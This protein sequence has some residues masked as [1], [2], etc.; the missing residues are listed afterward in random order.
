VHA[1]L[2]AHSSFADSENLS[3]HSGLPRIA[4]V[5][6][7]GTGKSAFAVRVAQTLRT[8]TGICAEIVSAD[9]MQLYRG[10]DIGTAKIPVAE[11]R[12]IAHHMLDVLEP[13]Q[14]AAVAAYQRD[15]HRAF[16]AIESRGNVPILV[17]GSGLYVNAALYTFHFPGSDPKV[18]SDLNARFERDGLAP[19]AEELVARD[20]NAHTTVDLKNPRR[21]IRALEVLKIT[22]EP[23]AAQLPAKPEPVRPVLTFGLHEERETLV[24]RLDERVTQMWRLGLVEEVRRLIPRGLQNGPTASRAIG[25]A[26]ALAYVHGQLSETEAIEQTQKLTRRY[27]RRQVSWFKRLPDV[28][29]LTSAE[30]TTDEA[31]EQV[32]RQWQQH[33]Q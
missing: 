30:S 8:V 27:A 28:K 18:R 9:A 33:Q 31:V 17:G 29:W 20:A 25:Y 4:V 26:Q 16:R 6:A 10:M 11:R 1:S 24:R 7:T 12:G 13:D 14:E 5:G 15:V 21:V 22:G 19:L 3:E 23:I 32:V 2:T